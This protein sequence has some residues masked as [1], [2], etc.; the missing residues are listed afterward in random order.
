VWFRK[1]FSVQ[2]IRVWFNTVSLLQGLPWA[3]IL[4]CIQDYAY[5]LHKHNLNGRLGVILQQ[6]TTGTVGNGEK[7][8]K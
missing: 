5:T 2:I 3:K 6:E 4:A 7:K 8:R 1:E